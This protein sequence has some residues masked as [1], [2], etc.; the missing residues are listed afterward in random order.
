[1][2]P[3]LHLSNIKISFKNVLSFFTFLRKLTIILG[4]FIAYSQD[5]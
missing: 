3:V 5:H 1:M 2:Q 4:T